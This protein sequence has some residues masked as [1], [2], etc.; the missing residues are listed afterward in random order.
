[1]LPPIKAISVACQNCGSPLQL[2]EGLRFVTCNYC[3]SE[4]EIVRDESSTHSVVLKRIEAKVDHTARRLRLM[5]L[6]L[7]LERLDAAWKEARKSY[8][9]ED[10]RG[11]VRRPDAIS[12]DLATAFYFGIGLFMLGTG[13]LNRTVHDPLIVLGILLLGVAVFNLVSAGRKTG[14]LDDAEK[15][16]EHRRWQL[17][18]AIRE[19]EV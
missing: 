11:G 13:L 1:M 7:A 18:N 14:L 19:L 4:L 17:I 15:R 6:R 3:A 2:A 8:M 9:Q 5:E 10:E 12:S 16:Y